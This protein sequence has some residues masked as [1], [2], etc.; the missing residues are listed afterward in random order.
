MHIWIYSVGGNTTYQIRDVKQC[1]Y[2]ISYV[3][4]VLYYPYMSSWSLSIWSY[5]PHQLLL[6]VVAHLVGYIL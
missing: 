3:F 6:Y 5:D 1:V 2:A 4:I